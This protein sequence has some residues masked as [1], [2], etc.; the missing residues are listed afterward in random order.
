M[1]TRAQQVFYIL[2]SFIFLTAFFVFGN[3]GE[4]RQVK[5]VGELRQSIQQQ[6]SVAWQQTIGDQPYFDDLAY[7]FDGV[8]AFY[9]QSTVA[10]VDLI[11]Q[12]Q[13]DQDIIYVYQRVYSDFASVFQARASDVAVE[14]AEPLVMPGKFMT[15]AA[16]YN[17]IPGDV[18]GVSIDATWVTLQD[19][20]TGQPYCLAIYNS[21]VNK[22]LGSCKYDNSYR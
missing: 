18:A 17:I 15:E 12:P 13:A 21:N 14:K 5:E 22:Y 10:Y 3:V 1:H 16:M 11:S 2:T 4:I 20:I 19:V 7:V 8:S 9:D 6:F